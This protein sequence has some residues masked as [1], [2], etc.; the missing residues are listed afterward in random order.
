MENLPG[1][2]LYNLETNIGE[3]NNRMDQHPEVIAQLTERM[4]RYVVN[5][6]STSGP[7]QKN[8][9]LVGCK[10]LVWIQKPKEQS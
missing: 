3:T 1:Y 10:Q 9:G 2:Q 8:D 5:G 4:T 7:V 6:R